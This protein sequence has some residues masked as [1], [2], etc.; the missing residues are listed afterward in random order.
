[1]TEIRKLADNVW[2]FIHKTSEMVGKIHTE[3]FGQDMHTEL[4]E[5]GMQ[6]PI[7]DL[8]WVAC[9]A[10]CYASFVEVNPEPEIGPGNSVI[11]GSGVFITPQARVGKYR[12]DFVLQQSRCVP[13]EHYPAVIV[14]LDGH[15]F[16]DK[17]KRQRAYEKS[18]DRFLVREGYRVLH[19]TGS[20]VVK[21]PFACA[22]EALM[23]SG[24]LVGMA[25]EEFDP[26]NPLGYELD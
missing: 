3:R 13:D 21:D 15:D 12:V 26:R 4:V 6:S 24:A 18:R 22:H 14:E 7:E 1:M 23:L 8:F 10:L 5:F 25:S 2:D 9:H 11:V 19:F 20:E 17:D 16:H